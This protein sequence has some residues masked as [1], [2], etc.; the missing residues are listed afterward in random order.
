MIEREQ[1]EREVN[2]LAIYLHEANEAPLLTS[3]QECELARQ[4]YLGKTA[5]VRLKE[6]EKNGLRPEEKKELESLIAQGKES[7]KG[8][9]KSNLR[10]VVGI[11]KKKLGRG[12]PFLDLIQEGNIGLMRAVDRFDPDRGNRFSTYATWWIRQAVGRAVAYQGRTIHL[13]IHK[14]EELTMV[15]RKK[16]MLTKELGQEPNLKELAESLDWPEEKVE[17]ILNLPKHP[18]SLDIPVGEDKNSYLV[19]FI[20]DEESA[21]PPEVATQEIIGEQLREVVD[22]LTPREAKVLRL[23]FGLD[24]GPK[25]TLEEVGEEFGLTR[26]RIRQIEAKARHKLRHPFRARKLKEYLK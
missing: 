7:R 15:N 25:R 21:S 1:D 17:S 10:L 24:G 16:K 22:S 9:I 3:E 12:V 23:R 11:A 4:H 6:L 8:L 26:E 5:E 20:K 19:E 18:I 2:L 14:I 13:P